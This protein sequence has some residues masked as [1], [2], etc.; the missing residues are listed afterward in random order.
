MVYRGRNLLSLACRS[1]AD[2]WTLLELYLPL[3]LIPVNSP[4]AS[5]ASLASSRQHK[6]RDDKGETFIL[7]WGEGGGVLDL[8]VNAP[9]RGIW[10]ISRTDIQRLVPLK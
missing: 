8:E 1:I 2:P 10:V 9:E 4:V 3:L 7:R 5:S 6:R